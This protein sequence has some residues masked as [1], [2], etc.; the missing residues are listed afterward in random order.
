MVLLL[1]AILSI[2]IGQTLFFKFSGA[3][4]SMHIFTQLGVEPWGRISLG[5]LELIAIVLL[6]VS[7]TSHYGTLAALG[8]ML[9]AI[10]S[11]VFLLGIV[12]LN[13]GG[14]LFILAVIS[15]LAALLLAYYQREEF[16]LLAAKLVIR[17]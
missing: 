5:I 2:I 13:D 17:R 6:W 14:K 3:A 8:L 1:K 4:E 7:S 12:V 11:H 16:K 10:A 15:F 9:G